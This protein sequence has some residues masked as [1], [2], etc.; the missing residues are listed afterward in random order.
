VAH[1]ATS[2]FSYSSSTKTFTNGPQGVAIPKVI[3]LG[4]PHHFD[5]DPDSTY[6]L[7]RIRI[8]N[9]I[10]CGS[11]FL[12]EADSDPTLHPFHPDPSFQIKAL[13][14]EKVLK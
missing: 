4:N 12:F 9:F 8:R 6:H 7:M 2:A 13:T 3:L 11:G 5:A 14:L 1:F 10:L